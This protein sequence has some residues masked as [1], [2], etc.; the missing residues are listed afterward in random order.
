MKKRM[1]AFIDYGVYIKYQ[2]MSIYLYA[3]PRMRENMK[4]KKD[5][6]F[7]RPWCIYKVSR[8]VNIFVCI[9]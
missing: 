7:D 9:S 6:Y 2:K 4:K 8:K 5:V 3:Y 1:C